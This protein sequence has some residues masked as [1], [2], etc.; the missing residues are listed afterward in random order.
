MNCFG[1]R[2]YTKGEESKFCR[3]TECGG[4]CNDN[5]GSAS[6]GEG[7]DDEDGDTDKDTDSDENNSQGSGDEEE[8]Q[9]EK[10]RAVW[11]SS[12]PPTKEEQ[13]TGSWY[14]IIYD[15]TKARM[16]YVGEV[17]KRF[18]AE[19]DGPVTALEVR[20]LKT[21][22]GSG[23]KLERNPNHLGNDDYVIAGPLISEPLKRSSKLNF[24]E[25]ENVVDLFHDVKGHDM[26]DWLHL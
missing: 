3:H 26:L 8:D 2:S 24:P 21:K 17:L 20:C 13:V 22:V 11:K 6:N 16:L 4:H 14:A 19:D 15:G 12:S 23:T 5:S 18:L 7:E 10:L 1:S 25:Y 9:A